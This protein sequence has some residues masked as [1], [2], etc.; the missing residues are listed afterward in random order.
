MVWLI[1]DSFSGVWLVGSLFNDTFSVTRLYSVD[2]RMISEWWIEKKN[3]GSGRGLI[4][5]YCHD[6][7]MEGLRKNTKNSVDIARRRGRESAA[8]PPEH[9]AGVLTTRPRRLV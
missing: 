5:R 1:D 3:L 9:E 6:F 7:R 2:D 8:G 4:L